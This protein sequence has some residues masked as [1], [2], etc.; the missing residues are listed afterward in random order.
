VK[1]VKLGSSA[2]EAVTYDE[3]KRTL[4]VEFRRGDSY[5]YFGVP[6]AIYRRLLKVESAGAFWNE[7]KD[8]FHYEKLE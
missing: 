7:V 2:I 1:R 3:T 6:K 8:D 4:V 5:R